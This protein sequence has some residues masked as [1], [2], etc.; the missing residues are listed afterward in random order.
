[1]AIPRFHCN[2]PLRQTPVFELPESVAHHAVRVLRRGVGDELV[3]FDGSG[4]EYLVRIDRIAGSAVTVARQT[5]TALEVESPLNL[6]LGQSLCAT[7][8]MDWIFQK[9]VELGVSRCSPLLAERNV[10][11]LSEER[12]QRRQAHW[13]RVVTAACEQS[14]RNRI[15]LVD[16]VQSL[17]HWLSGLPVD[18]MR[19]MLSPRGEFNL[20]QLK[21]PA[22]PV[23]LLVGPEGG[24]T[25]EEED[26]AFA[27]GFKTLKLGPRILRTETAA[28]AMVATLQGLWGDFME[29]KTF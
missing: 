20:S 28:L 22:G 1:M 14:G 2:I 23:V 6:W 13:Q 11:R 27:V 3:L 18:G 24:L 5:F 26:A 21:P 12:A 9:S 7:E 10:V 15:P 19:L 16:P 17:R 29:V 25:A 4:G 8:K